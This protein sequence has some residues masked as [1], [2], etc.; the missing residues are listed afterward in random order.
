MA[1]QWGPCCFCAKE[2]KEEGS[3]PCRV[4]VDTAQGKWQVWFCHGSC[5]RERL[6]DLPDAPGFF[7]PAHF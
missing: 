1:V 4:K 6:A 7:E 5:F 2:I 3:D